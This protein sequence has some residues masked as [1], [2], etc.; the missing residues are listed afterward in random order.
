MGPVSSKVV[1]RWSPLLSKSVHG[2]QGGPMANLEPK[3]VQVP[4]V[5]QVS[6]WYSG[7]SQGKSGAQK[8]SGPNSKSK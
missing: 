5:K 3:S 6:S 7:G 2:I 1:Q 8:C 4:F